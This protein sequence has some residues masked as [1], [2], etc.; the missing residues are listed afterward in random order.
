MAK[1]KIITDLA[2]DDVSLEV[3]LKRITILTSD[4]EDKT[5]FTWAQNELGGYSD[6]ADIPKYRILHG[7]IRGSFQI[8][9]YGFVQTQSNAKLPTIGFEREDVD[10]FCST[11]FFQ[12]ISAL[13]DLASNDSCCRSLPMESFPLFEHGTNITILSAKIT[14]VKSQIQSILSKIESV[15]LNILIELEKNYGNL[16]SL[17]I[18][19]KA[20]QTQNTIE[21]ELVKIIYE[22]NRIQIGDNNKISK[23][24]I[25]T[26]IRGF[27]KGKNKK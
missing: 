23:T 17:D 1:S 6:D 26:G 13:R 10:H 22:D 27:F 3:V 7:E 9:G 15:S 12:G 11:K 5:I 18:E 16:D 14:F 2:N 8:A 19:Q 20:T 25:S 4:F 24:D 21:K